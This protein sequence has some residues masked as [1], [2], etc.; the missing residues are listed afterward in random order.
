MAWSSGNVTD[1]SGIS[2]IALPDSN[3][4]PAMRKMVALVADIGGTHARF[5]LVDSRG[6]PDQERV[7]AV[8]DHDGPIA[9]IS[10]YLAE[11]GQPKPESAAVAIAA[12]VTDAV[13]RLTNGSWRFDREEIR[14]HF[15]F[16]HLHL[17]NDFAALALA[18]PH[19]PESELHLLGGGSPVAEATKA[20]IGPGTG[21]GVS[22]L[23]FDRGHWFPLVGEGGHVS[24]A[25]A[26]AR[27]SAILERAWRK[28][29]HVSTERLV[30]GSGLPFLYRLVADIDGKVADMLTPREII[31]HAVAGSD[32]LC[33]ATIDTFCAMLGGLAGNLALTLGAR[34]GLYIGGGIVSRLGESFDRSP[35]RQRFEAKGRFSA[36]LAEI[37]AYV[38]LSTAPALLGAAQALA[39]AG[40]GR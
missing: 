9:A 34:G 37:P 15:G 2:S 12:P 40:D 35:F 18:I 25:P 3:S 23:A 21:L 6:V 28:F 27:E 20:V 22:G 26:D 38:I 33:L 29:P 24:L 39:M 8:A 36:Y 11:V 30:S 16:R 14:L 13:P 7:L 17:L 1:R 10:A 4:F 32:A 5:A 31:A 19:L